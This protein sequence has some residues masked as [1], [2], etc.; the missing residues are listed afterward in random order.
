MQRTLGLLM[1]FLFVP[2]S[3]L[4]DE[5]DNSVTY[6]I[7]GY[8]VLAASQV[9]GYYLAAYARKL[10]QTPSAQTCQPVQAKMAAVASPRWDFPNG[11]PYPGSDVVL[12]PNQVELIKAARSR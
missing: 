6:S 5:G 8:C 1:S 9:P 12:S 10:G 11:Q 7:E 3:V 4:A 2:G